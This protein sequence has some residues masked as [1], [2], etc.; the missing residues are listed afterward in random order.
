[1]KH[2]DS[3]TGD[4]RIFPPAL[5]RLAATAGLACLTLAG[6]CSYATTGAPRF[7]PTH[8][9][10]PDS[11]STLTNLDLG[12]FTQP[13][14]EITGAVSSVAFANNSRRGQVGSL[15]QLLQGRIAGLIAESSTSGGVSLRV[16]GGGGFYGAAPLVVIDG[17]PLPAGV[18][19]EN[20]LSGVDP[21]D[22]VR[23]DVL[24]DISATAI[25]GTRGSAGVVLIT[26]RHRTQ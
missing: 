7:G 24:K 22:V 26:L 5:A 25:Y 13:R 15:V 17:D 9:A 16:R 18:A 2:T 4:R 14:S 12:Y 19:L 10:V 23:V 1:M 21:A 3:C 6:A 8:A 20:L 11:L